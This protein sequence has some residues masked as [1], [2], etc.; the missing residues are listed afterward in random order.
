ME[1][2]KIVRQLGLYDEIEDRTIQRYLPELR[3]ALEE[4]DAT[5]VAPGAASS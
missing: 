3:R 5:G 2:R 4:I 1:E